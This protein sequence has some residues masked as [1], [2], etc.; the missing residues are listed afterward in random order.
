[1]GPKCYRK[2]NKYFALKDKVFAYKR[3]LIN[4]TWDSI[5]KWIEESHNHINKDST[6]E[7]QVTPK[8]HITTHPE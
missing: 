4:N 1:M 2:H 6:V 7:K 8:R 5:N 3:Y